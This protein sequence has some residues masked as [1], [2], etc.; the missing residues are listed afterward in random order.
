MHAS[1][2]ASSSLWACIVAG[3][4]KTSIYQ[5]KSTKKVDAFIHL[6][7]P[8]IQKSEEKKVP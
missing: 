4:N 5:N 8:F 7:L 3:N 1:G 6:Q 2:Q